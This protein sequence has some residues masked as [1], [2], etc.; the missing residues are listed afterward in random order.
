MDD[1]GG[2]GYVTLRKRGCGCWGR[3]RVC[4]FKEEGVWMSGEGKG[5]WL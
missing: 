5:M 3:G 1:G 4:G 2:G